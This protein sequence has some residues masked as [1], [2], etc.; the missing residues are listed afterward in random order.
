M[1]LSMSQIVRMTRR[2]AVRMHD[3]KQLGMNWV[4]SETNA[5]WDRKVK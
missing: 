5:G 3:D 1:L 2:R 4:R